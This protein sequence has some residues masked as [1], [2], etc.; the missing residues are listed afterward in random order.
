M[1]PSSSWG[2]VGLRVRTSMCPRDCDQTPGTVAVQ[3]E[4]V[5]RISE[6]QYRHALQA[7]IS[8]GWRSRANRPVPVRPAQ[9]SPPSGWSRYPGLTLKPSQ[10]W[11]LVRHNPGV[12]GCNSAEGVPPGHGTGQDAPPPPGGRR[13]RGTPIGSRPSTTFCGL[14]C[15]LRPGP[16]IPPQ[17]PCLSSAPRPCPG[18]ADGLPG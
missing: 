14:D 15:G 8:R 6:V 10:P 4:A 11:L 5:V 16:G 2:P 7:G 13:R 17:R 1:R 18:S 3:A 12:P 9:P